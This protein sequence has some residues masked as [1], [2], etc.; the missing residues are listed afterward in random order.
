[1]IFKRILA[2]IIDWIAAILV[3]QIIPDGPDYGTQSHALLTLLIFA[4]QVFLFTW[5]TGSS[6]G[7]RIFGLR[8]QDINTQQKPRL[9]QSLIRTLLII[10]VFP[11]LLSTAS[12]RG[13]HDRIAKTQI[14]QIY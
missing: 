13:L 3:V 6:F 5:L 8:V 11:P 10:L 2:L 4:S 14:V 1:M 7:Q 9:I 12:G